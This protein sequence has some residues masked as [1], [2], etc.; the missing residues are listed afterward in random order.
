MFLY[1][2]ILFLKVFC[3]SRVIIRNAGEL[4]AVQIGSVYQFIYN[5]CKMKTEKMNRARMVIIT[6]ALTDYLEHYFEEHGEPQDVAYL[7][8]DHFEEFIHWAYD[9]LIISREE[10]DL[11]LGGSEWELI[12]AIKIGAEV[13]MI[14]AA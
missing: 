9:D 2:F 7:V 4:R 8:R 6:E 12:E 11:L 3:Q 1:L 5:C 13:K 10:K 14:D